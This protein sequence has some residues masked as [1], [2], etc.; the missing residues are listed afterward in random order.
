MSFP[1]RPEPGQK[2]NM[3][4]CLTVEESQTYGPNLWFFGEFFIFVIFLMKM[5]SI[6]FGNWGEIDIF[7]EEFRVIKL[8]EKLWYSLHNSIFSKWKSEEKCVILI[9]SF[10]QTYN[11]YKRKIL[12]GTFYWILGFSFNLFALWEKLIFQWKLISSKLSKIFNS[13]R[14]INT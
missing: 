14:E 5:L 4:H 10:L 9:C 1:P 7:F 13:F 6:F 8:S 2:N 12:F 3:V 11:N